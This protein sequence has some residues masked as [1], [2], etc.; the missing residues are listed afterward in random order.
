MLNA[1][2]FKVLPR[3]PAVM[4]QLRLYT[5]R[6]Y[7]EFDWKFLPERYHTKKRLDHSPRSLGNGIFPCVLNRYGA[8]A[9]EFLTEGYTPGITVGFLYDPSNAK[10]ELTTP[11]KGVDLVLTIAADPRQNPD[12]GKIIKRLVAGR[13][14]IVEKEKAQGLKCHTRIHLRDEYGCENRWVLL[15]AQKCLADVVENCQT[16]DEQLGVIHKYFQHLLT[17][18]FSDPD[19]E[20]ALKTLHPF[21]DAILKREGTK[22][23]GTLAE[24]PSYF[25]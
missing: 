8:I 6:L 18:L 16:E 7:D 12:C 11:D 23:W 17:E 13:D 14:R 22:G 2:D 15:I 25:G 10:V 1:A 9:I 3:V 20:N 19:L 5:E 21:P 4:T 24:T